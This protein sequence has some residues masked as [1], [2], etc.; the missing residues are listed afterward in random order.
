MHVAKVLADRAIFRVGQGLIVDW[1]ITTEIEI[2]GFGSSAIFDAVLQLR[3]IRPSLS[4]VEFMLGKAR[5][6]DRLAG[7]LNARQE[8]ALL[9]MFAEGIDGFKGGLS[10]KN[11][12]TI[13]GA[14]TATATRDLADMVVKGALVRE[15]ELKSTRYF[16]KL[17]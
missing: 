11:Y 13:T 16:L 1:L 3:R 6:F 14:P 5:L 15:G 2:V 4:Q 17:E 12:I 10:A 7:Q 9:R 8:K